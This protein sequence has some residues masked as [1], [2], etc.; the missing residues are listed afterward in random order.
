[1]IFDNRYLRIDEV[2]VHFSFS[3]NDANPFHIGVCCSHGSSEV[4]SLAVPRPKFTRVAC[5]I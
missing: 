1:M 3:L 5:R 2:H 4:A